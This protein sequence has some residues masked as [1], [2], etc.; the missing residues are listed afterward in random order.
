[1]SLFHF[2]YPYWKH[3]TL[4]RCK[5]KFSR[6]LP[7]CELGAVA[8]ATDITVDYDEDVDNDYPRPLSPSIFEEWGETAPEVRDL[9]ITRW[10]ITLTQ[11]DRSEIAVGDLSAHAVWYGPTPGSRSLNIGVSVMTEYRGKGI[12]AMAQHL[13]AEELHRQGIVRVEAQTD[14]ERRRTESAREGWLQVRRH[15]SNGAGADRRFAR[16][17]GLVS[18]VL[19]EYRRRVNLVCRFVFQFSDRF[20][21][22]RKQCSHQGDTRR[23]HQR[24]RRSDPAGN[25][26]CKGNP[27]RSQRV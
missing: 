8:S 13:L 4:A 22:Q 12:G 5:R 11:I 7:N 17:P 10:L 20:Q 26:T 2:S 6:A 3:A 14:I 21:C 19:R 16:Y 1:L 25:R 18:R 9:A 23:Y 15:S 27:Y 24:S